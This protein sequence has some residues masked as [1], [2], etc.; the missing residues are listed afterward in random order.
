MKVLRA[1][2]YGIAGAVELACLAVKAV[3][4][5]AYGIPW[6]ICITCYELGHRRWEGED[7]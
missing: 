3:A 1:I 2:G 4:Q 5:A 6:L 7:A